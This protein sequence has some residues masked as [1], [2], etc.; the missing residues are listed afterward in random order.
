MH[1]S[2]FTLWV[3]A[4]TQGIGTNFQLF[5]VSNAQPERGSLCNRYI[6]VQMS[7]PQGTMIVGLTA[8]THGQCPLLNCTW[9]APPPPQQQD[10]D[11]CINT[12]KR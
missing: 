4:P 11:T 5:D 6:Y 3:G 12:N 2:L 10:N 9:V 1:V 7:L 8:P